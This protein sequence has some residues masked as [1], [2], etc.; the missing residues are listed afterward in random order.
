VLPFRRGLF[1]SVL[2][3]RQELRTAS[4]RYYLGAGNGEA[5]VADGVCWWG[6]ATFG[7]HIC[8]FL[9]LKNVSA[10]IR[11]D[12]APVGGTDRFA[13]SENAHSRVARSYERLGRRLDLVTAPEEAR[14]PEMVR[15][16]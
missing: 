5:T 1:H 6:D 7:P 14:E 4:L 16:V 10:R 9:G 15:A 8:K 3:N 13:L 2:D 11:F 12:D